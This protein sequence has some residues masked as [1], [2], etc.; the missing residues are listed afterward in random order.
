MYDG[1]I[2]TCA[3][4]G[5]K[6]QT[7]IAILLPANTQHSNLITSSDL[8]TFDEKRFNFSI[9]RQRIIHAMI[10]VKLLA[11][12]MSIADWVEHKDTASISTSRKVVADDTITYLL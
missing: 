12:N 6:A 5:I 4:D 1:S 10:M 3:G 7:H 11:E 2:R 9:Q 8:S